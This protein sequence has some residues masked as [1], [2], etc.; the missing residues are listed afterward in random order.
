M[1][2][3]FR[4]AETFD[5]EFLLA[6]RKETMNV[7][8]KNVSGSIDEK[9]HLERI[10]Y[11]FNDAEIVTVNNVNAGLLKS[12]NDEAG[13]VIVQIQLSSDFQGKGIGSKI[14]RKVLDQA[15]ENEKNVTLSVLKGNP[16]KDLYH[17][18]GFDVISKSD[19]EYTMLC[20]PKR[21]Y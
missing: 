6:L 16:A 8:L 17:R 20:Q 18:L 4:P 2:V 21:A 13:W 19:I 15:A 12:Y 1:N 9:S 3:N 14:V 11:R 5:L 7:H 10:M